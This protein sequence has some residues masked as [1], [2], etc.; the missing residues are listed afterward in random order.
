[1]VIPSAAYSC[2]KSSLSV[3]LLEV[4]IRLLDSFFKRITIPL[5]KQTRPHFR[6]SIKRFKGTLLFNSMLRFEFRLWYVV[7]PVNDLD[8]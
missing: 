8:M 4:C 5:S 3:L 7:F 2:S 1:M 6:I